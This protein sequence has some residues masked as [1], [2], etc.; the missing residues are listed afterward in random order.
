MEPNPFDLKIERRRENMYGTPDIV[1]YRDGKPVLLVPDD[2]GSPTR[3]LSYKDLKA[4]QE[5]FRKYL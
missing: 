4:L 5:E 1:T 2:F 3:D